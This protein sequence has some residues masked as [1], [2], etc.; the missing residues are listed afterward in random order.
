LRPR[1]SAAAEHAAGTAEIRTGRIVAIAFA[2]ALAACAPQIRQPASRALAPDG[3]PAQVYRDA[4]VRGDAI[5]VIDPRASLVAIE[6]RRAGAL[7][8]LGHDHV[9]ASHDI[10][11]FVWPGAG[12][13]DL[14]VPLDRLTV[15]EPALR[16]EAHFDTRL[17]AEDIAGTRRNMLTR[18]LD[19]ER[20]PFVRIHVQRAGDADPPAHVEV[21]ITLHGTTRIVPMPIRMS[22]RPAG[23]DVS[24]QFSL[25]QSHF[26]IEP[27]SILGGAIQVQDE[28]S[29]RFR[30]HAIRMQ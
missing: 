13:A 24:G 4:A 10:E 23:V 2:V 8:R 18:V 6:V 25:R 29:L 27:L 14:Y 28:I 11:G 5:Y 26:D 21:A 15:D 30:L 9:V 16:A 1:S 19:T 17:S 12:R 3:F 7:A 22:T 20:Y